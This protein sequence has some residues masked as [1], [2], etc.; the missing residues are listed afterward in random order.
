LRQL[1]RIGAAEL[2]AIAESER[3]VVRLL[4]NGIR[5]HAP[6]AAMLYQFA[7]LIGGR[8]TRVAG[9]EQPVFAWQ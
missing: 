7:E 3:P 2:V 8:T 1:T 9:L 4:L 6:T 5:I